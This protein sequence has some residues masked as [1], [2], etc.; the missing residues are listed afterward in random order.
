MFT[1]YNLESAQLLSERF[2]IDDGRK[3][4]RAARLL[5]LKTSQRFQPRKID[6]S[7][8]DNAV[9]HEREQARFESGEYVPLCDILRLNTAT[10]E[11]RVG[12]KL[13]AHISKKNHLLIA[14]TKDAQ[15][16]AADK[17]SLISIRA[18]VE[19]IA[20]DSALRDLLTSCQTDHAEKFK[21]HE[22]KLASTP[23]DIERVYINYDSSIH[24]LAI[25]CMRHK[26]G[27]GIR[28][29]KVDGKGFHPVRIYGAGDL[30]VAYI[31]DSDGQTIARALVWPDKK[32]YSR[33]YAKGDALH[34]ALKASG[35]TQSAY[36]NISHDSFDG[37][38]MLAVYSDDGNLIAPYL[39]EV[40]SASLEGDALVMRDGGEFKCSQ[41]D[42]YAENESDRAF[43]QCCEETYSEDD[44]ATVYTDSRQHNGESWCED[45]RSNN[46][47]YCEGERE[48]FSDSVDRTIINEEYYSQRYG[49]NYAR[50]CDHYEE[51]TFDSLTEV[52]ISESGDTESWSDSALHND[53]LEYDGRWYSSDMDVTKVIVER[54]VLKSNP[55]YDSATRTIFIENC[56]F[57]DKAALIPQYLIDDEEV[58]VFEHDGQLYLEGY[59]DNYPVARERYDVPP[60]S[61]ESES[62][63]A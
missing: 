63:A 56:W 8:Q 59:R 7:A 38:K 31:A 26:H 51:Y 23:E 46:A 29:P 48:Y 34:N 57:T 44:L 35:Y 60:A 50:Y 24:P 37:A 30:A 42:G 52:I 21:K 14:Y 10:Y 54:Y 19:M 61:E 3:A 58:I 9:W 2:V 15:K 25:S 49:D 32:L 20:D 17:Q 40:G 18:F 39:D 28:W 53:A 36:Y 41:T 11:T 62:V 12:V 1:L 33:M 4:A 55:R 5:S 16:G 6:A 22:F 47:F 13:F 27:Y 43:C 45:C